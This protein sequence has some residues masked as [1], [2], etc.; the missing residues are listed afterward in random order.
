[1]VG[2]SGPSIR[3][4]SSDGSPATGQCGDALRPALHGRRQARWTMTLFAWL[5]YEERI[6]DSMLAKR[7]LPI[8]ALV[9]PFAAR[10]PTFLKRKRLERDRAFLARADA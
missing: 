4:T 9:H 10:A 7:T 8:S 5:R 1:V 6:A 2:R 3:T